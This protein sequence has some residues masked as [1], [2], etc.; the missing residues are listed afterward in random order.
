M[1]RCMSWDSNHL[2]LALQSSLY[3]LSYNGRSQTMILTS[4]RTKKFCFRAFIINVV[5]EMVVFNVPVAVVVVIPIDKAV[6]SL[7][8]LMVVTDVVTP[9]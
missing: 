9:T 7:D 4:N 3:Q 8:I 5:F 6:K 2:P 1:K